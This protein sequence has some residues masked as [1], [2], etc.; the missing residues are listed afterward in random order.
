MTV[1]GHSPEEIAANTPHI[2]EKNLQAL[3]VRHLQ[4][5]HNW[6]LVEMATRAPASIT[7]MANRHPETY[8]RMVR[9]MWTAAVLRSKPRLMPAA[10]YGDG[11]MMKVGTNIFQIGPSTTLWD[12]VSDIYLDLRTS[13]VG[14]LGP[15]QATVELGVAIGFL[16]EVT[17]QFSYNVV[18]PVVN[19]YLQTNQPA[20]YNDIG[21]TL[22]QL[23]QNWPLYLNNI[24]GQDQ[25]AADT[26]TLGVSQGATYTDF[27]TTYDGGFAYGDY[28]LMD[29]AHEYLGGSTG[30]GGGGGGCLFCKM[31]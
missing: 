24:A 22:D 12:T 21:G 6:E 5:F 26:I 2:V 27:N 7:I 28:G 4:G 17:W 16:V 19:Q 30:G 15:L 8:K 1:F 18:G 11:Q 9:S 29:G 14:A 13:P 3:P 25:L 20:L 23:M 10:W 31:N